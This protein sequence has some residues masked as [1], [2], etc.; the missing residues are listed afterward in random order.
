MSTIP[1]HKLRAAVRAADAKSDNPFIRSIGKI[2]ELEEDL[3][4]VR[5]MTVEEHRAR[6]EAVCRDA[7]RIEA[8]KA[9]MGLP[10]SQPHPWPESTWEL[11]KRLRANVHSQ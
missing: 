7:V 4:G 6:L 10:V 11:L 8:V 3:E 9:K 1:S 5:A 2:C